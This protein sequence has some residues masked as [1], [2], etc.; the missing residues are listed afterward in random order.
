MKQYR[1]AECLNQIRLI[2]RTYQDME[3]EIIYFNWTCSGMEFEFTGT[4]LLAQVYAVP[5]DEYDGIPPIAPKRRVF[6]WI[7]VFLDEEEVP[8]RRMEISSEQE[9][10]IIFASERIE[11][12]KIRIIKLSENAKGK[13][14]IGSFSMEGSITKL[15]C[16]T[17]KRRSMEFIGD[18]I[19]CGFGNETQEK[20]RF[21]YSGEENGWMSHAAVAARLLQ[22][23]FNMICVSGITVGE[24]IGK[25]KW[26]LNPMQSLYPY[27]DRLYEESQKNNNSLTEWNFKLWIPD[28]IVINLGTN[29]STVISMEGDYRK[30]EINFERN[31]Y[32]FLQL[33]RRLNGPKPV[34]LCTLGSMDYYLYENLEK[35]VENYTKDTK[36]TKVKCFKY[37]KI[38][39]QEGYGACGHPSMSTQI[40]MGTELADYIKEL[41][42][43]ID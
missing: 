42:L 3:Q 11:T 19:T 13:V 38:K 35:A 28:L 17:D 31:Y 36:D 22:A 40:R 43:F 34:L 10:V 2:G 18:S 41:G 16:N 6:P 7:A 32:E 25:I 30:G 4:C 27:T 33:V 14:G 23:D 5:A 9:T 20:E 24:G 8:I 15:L 37:G 29:D 26:P 21:F 12:H 39:L 1:I